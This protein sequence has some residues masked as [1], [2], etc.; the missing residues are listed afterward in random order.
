VQDE[1]VEKRAD[2][3]VAGGQALDMIDDIAA[4]ADCGIDP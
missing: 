3:E 2:S 4:E 1:K